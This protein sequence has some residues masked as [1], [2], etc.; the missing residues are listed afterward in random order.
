M[1]DDKGFFLIWN[2][3]TRKRSL[4]DVPHYLKEVTVTDLQAPLFLITLNLDI[5]TDLWQ[6]AFIIYQSAIVVE[7]PAWK[8][9]IVCIHETVKGD[10]ILGSEIDALR[11][12]NNISN[13]KSTSSMLWW[14]Q[15]MFPGIKSV[16][17][18]LSFFSPKFICNDIKAL[19][20]SN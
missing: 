20:V 4:F 10:K 12:N 17:T 1:T 3:Q 5:H 13:S 15:L 8:V 14:K 19:M 7:P 6:C 11:T 2:M 18:F 9:T 16:I